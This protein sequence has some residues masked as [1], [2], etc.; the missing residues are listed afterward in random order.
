MLSNMAQ[1]VEPRLCPHGAA[2]P[3]RPQVVPRALEELPKAR[4][5]EG[6]SHHERTVPRHLPPGQVRQEVEEDRRRGPW[7]H[8]QEPR[9]VVAGLQGKAAQTT[10]AEP[11]E[12]ERQ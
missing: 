10:A 4:P 8:T 6:L 1:R 9:Q 11:E 3:P 2:P 7:P 12:E 5:Q